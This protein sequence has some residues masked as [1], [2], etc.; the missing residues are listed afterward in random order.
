[1]NSSRRTPR[2]C[3][4]VPERHAR[5]VYLVCH[6]RADGVAASCPLFRERDLP[7][8]VLCRHV[9]G[10]SRWQ[11]QAELVGGGLNAV[12]GRQQSPDVEEPLPRLGERLFCIRA[13][14]QRDSHE[15]HDEGESEQD[16][17]DAVPTLPVP[18]CVSSDR[19]LLLV[20][21]LRRGRRG[22][23]GRRRRKGRAGGLNRPTQAAISAS[24][25]P[26]IVF[27][28]LA[29]ART[30]VTCRFSESVG[31]STNRHDSS[32]VENVVASACSQ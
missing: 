31:R 26:V 11:S 10:T 15:R 16:D 27:S 13:D 6:E 8:S 19:G 4:R 25:L 28:A 2:R 29:V 30:A 22:G 3:S 1:M 9:R 17:G 12:E 24:G 18:P 23:R 20:G 32:A 7:R 5:S 14:V 21:L